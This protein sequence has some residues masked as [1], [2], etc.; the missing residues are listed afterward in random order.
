MEYE[1]KGVSNFSHRSKRKNST[2]DEELEYWM[3]RLPEALKSLPIIRLAIPGKFQ[4]I[5]SFYEN[6]Y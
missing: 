6:L 2:V 4:N 5:F 1:I 3:T